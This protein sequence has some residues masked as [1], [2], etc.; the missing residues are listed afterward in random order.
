MSLFGGLLYSD[1]AEP[2]HRRVSPVSGLTRRRMSYA[3][4]LHESVIYAKIVNIEN[5]GGQNA[6]FSSPV[7]SYVF[8]KAQ[9]SIKE[10]DK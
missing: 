1:E 5:G 9:Y 2:H 10:C 8:R 7:R 6:E 4:L 3:N